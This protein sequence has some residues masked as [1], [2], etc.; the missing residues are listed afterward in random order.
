MKPSYRHSPEACRRIAET[1]RAAMADP[2]VRQKISERTK[3][4]MRTPATELKLLRGA[5]RGARLGVRQTFVEEVL[6]PL[7]S[8]PKGGS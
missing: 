7:F 2:A 1:T 4:A 5:W 6:A 8:G 3:L